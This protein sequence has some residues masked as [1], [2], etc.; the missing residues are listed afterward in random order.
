MT[1]I[2]KITNILTD[3]KYKITPKSVDFSD[4]ISH[5]K[6][7]TSFSSQYNDFIVTDGAELSS[8]VIQELINDNDNQN[9]QKLNFI[10]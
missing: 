5:S 8:D 1:I 9:E 6:T 4:V 2:P 10:A 3:I 7:K